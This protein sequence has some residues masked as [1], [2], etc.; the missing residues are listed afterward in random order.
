MIDHVGIYGSRV[1]DGL[2]AFKGGLVLFVIVAL[3][4]YQIKNNW[5]YHKF[6]GF[7]QTSSLSFDTD[8]GISIVWVKLLQT[9]FDNIIYE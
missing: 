9:G 7:M 5:N 8:N 4:Q 1:A 2:S 3:I 6:L